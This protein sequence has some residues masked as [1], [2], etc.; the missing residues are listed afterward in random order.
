MAKA[1]TAVAARRVRHQ[2]LRQTLSGTLARPR[3]NVYRSSRY[4]YA[5]VID[6][7]AGHTMAAANSREVAGGNVKT[8]A[9]RLVGRLIAE[10]AKA[11]G[12][13]QVVFDRGGFKYH[14]RV[15]ALAE[16]SREEGLEF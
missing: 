16:A 5:Q 6:D 7:T 8:D 3:L 2:R 10:R 1:K 9:A 12:I 13:K 14:G 4:T 15:Q 11:K